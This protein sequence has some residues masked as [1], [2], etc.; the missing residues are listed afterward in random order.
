M[1]NQN[2]EMIGVN[3]YVSSHYLN[4]SLIAYQN[5]C[6]K[7]PSLRKDYTR[8]VR[9]AF[10]ILGIWFFIK[11]NNYLELNAENSNVFC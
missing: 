8:F 10:L 4:N 7:E 6:V 2:L 1:W 11:D 9:I 3:K 5:S